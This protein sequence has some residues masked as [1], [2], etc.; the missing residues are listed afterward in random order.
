MKR[1]EFHWG[2]RISIVYTL[3][4]LGTLGFVAFAMTQRVDL[5]REDYYEQSLQYDAT[6]SARSNADRLAD[7]ISV[8]YRPGG[9]IAIQ[10]PREHVGESRGSV[11]FY[12]PDEPNADVTLKLV[13]AEDGIMNI[14]ASGFKHG[15]W[16]VIVRWK[17]YDKQYEHQSVV[18]IH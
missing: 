1:F 10:I 5:V 4:A 6:Q 17:A 2:W 13:S 16:K 12:R 11:L 18:Y 7:R 15:V 8:S 9:D 14:D 3:F